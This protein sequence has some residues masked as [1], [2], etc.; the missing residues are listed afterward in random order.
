MGTITERDRMALHQWADEHMGEQ[1]ADTLMKSLRP[2]GLGDVATKDDLE[3]LRADTKREFDRL[4]AELE[5]L[6]ADTKRDFDRLRAELEASEARTRSEIDRLHAGL[7]ASS[8]EIQGLRVA[9]AEL[10]EFIKQQVEA[11]EAAWTKDL[12]SATAQQRSYTDR[13]AFRLVIVFLIATL[14]A[15]LGQSAIQ[16]Y[17]PPPMPPM[18]PLPDINV[19]PAAPD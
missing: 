16:Y 9:I 17:A 12:A 10:R 4:R 8:G 14:G 18:P 1:N 11:L 3:A 5:S 7:E 6:R 15:L 13:Q 19:Y 2:A